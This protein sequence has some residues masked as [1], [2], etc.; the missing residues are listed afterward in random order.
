MV[1][2]SHVPL[3]Y[4]AQR[5]GPFASSKPSNWAPFDPFSTEVDLA[6]QQ[7]SKELDDPR[8]LTVKQLPCHRDFVMPV[9]ER[10][11]RR[12]LMDV[13]SAFLEGLRGVILLRGSNSQ[14]KLRFA[15]CSCYGCYCSGTIFLHPFPRQELRTIHR[16]LPKPSILQEYTRAGARIRWVNG[17]WERTFTPQALRTFYL[18]DVLMHELGH[19]V[20][21]HSAE[22]KPIA[23]QE[24]FAEW[25][26]AE[27]GYR[28]TRSPSFPE[29]NAG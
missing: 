11:V 15:N 6:L 3:R 4:R 22:R 29:K 18:Q 28:R 7:F 21:R 12:F 24:L 16:G 13:P 1:R 23:K 14:H 19:H 8:Q 5:T 20:D 27:Y 17:I 25:F 26:A 10:D 2:H 9:T